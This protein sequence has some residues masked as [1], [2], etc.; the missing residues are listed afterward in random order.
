MLAARRAGHRERRATSGQRGSNRPSSVRSSVLCAP[1]L[2]AEL[3]ARAEAEGDGCDARA[4]IEKDLHRTFPQHH[5]FDAAGDGRTKLREVLLAY[6]MR[7]VNIGYCQSLNYVAAM[8]LVALQYQDEAC[9]W[10]LCALC[11]RFFPDFYSRTMTG[12]RI[13]QGLFASFVGELTPQVAAHFEALGVPLETISTQWF[14][15]L[16][17]NVLPA[18][19]LLRL[20]D[21]MFWE[22]PSV[23][24]RAGAALLDCYKEPILAAADFHSISVLLPRI[25]HDLWHADQL[26]SAMYNKHPVSGRPQQK[27]ALRHVQR[28]RSVQRKML[29]KDEVRELQ[30][31]THFDAAQIETLRTYVRDEVLLEHQSADACVREA[32]LQPLVATHFGLLYLRDSRRARSHEPAALFDVLDPHTDGFVKL[33]QLL[34]GLSALCRGDDDEA[35]GFAFETFDTE[36]NG[37]LS[38]RSL[39]RI[40][41]KAYARYAPDQGLSPNIDQ[42]AR[43]LMSEMGGSSLSLAQF[44]YLV[45][46]EPVLRVWLPL[47]GDAPPSAYEHRLAVATAAAA[48]LALGQEASTPGPTADG[49]GVLMSEAIAAAV[50]RAIA[51]RVAERGRSV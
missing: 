5:A 29:E 36:G 28:E 31:L 1:N 23:L 20:W 49:P 8:L 22:G 18:P 19:T 45:R 32:H 35:L 44:S 40:L 34:L 33:R 38:V 6:S 4:E 2:Y 42:Y 25:G 14:L 26:I 10:M 48:G 9:F 11:E 7:N 50:F 39:A 41:R 3:L 46:T 37:A 51:G 30:E 27:V 43:L 15:C 47:E 24:L 13:E 21:T 17:V 12:I 16:F